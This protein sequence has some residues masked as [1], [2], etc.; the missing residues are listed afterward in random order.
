MV[1]DVPPMVDGWSVFLQARSAVTSAH[2]PWRLDY[3][4]A[5]S[6]LDGATPVSNHY[7]A[8]FDASNGAMKLFPIS[9]EQLAAP[10]S[11]PH[12]FNT[13]FSIGICFGLCAGIQIPVGHPAPYQ[14]LIGQPLISPTYMFGLHYQNVK[15]N[16]QPVGSE[17]TLPVIATVST[18]ARD[19]DVTLIGIEPVDGVE[20]YHLR[21]KPL[22]KPNDNRLREL[23]VGMDDHL[24]RKAIISGNFTMAPLVDVPWT[25]AFSVVDGEPFVI[26]E[27]TSNVLYLPHRRVVRD[28]TIA[29]ENISGPDDSLYDRPLLTPAQQDYVL[30]E[31]QGL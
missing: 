29:F 12:G 3:T 23:W 10:P 14:D 28:A 18:M 17:S 9:D 11:V 20:S 13:K 6:G 25:I 27:S 21:L 15:Y 2:Y 8:S 31:P 26:R 24:P 4:I 7:R 22:R 19:Y 5:I 16:I 1:A 30:T